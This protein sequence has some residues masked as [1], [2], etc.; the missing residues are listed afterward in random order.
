MEEY[1]EKRL[2]AKTVFS[3]AIRYLKDHLLTT[4]R[5]RVPSILETDVHWVLT[6]PAIWTDAAKQFMR[7]AA[8]DVCMVPYA[9]L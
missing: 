3:M 2:P 5:N 6:V 9:K 4:V 7:E 1:N 8:T